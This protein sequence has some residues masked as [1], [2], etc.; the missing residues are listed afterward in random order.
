MLDKNEN[1]VGYLLGRWL[2]VAERAQQAAVDPNNSLAARNMSALGTSPLA[3]FNR[4]SVGT[5]AHLDK[6]R[7]GSGRGMAI[8]LVKLLG[9][10]FAAIGSPPRVMSLESKALLTIGYYTQKQD[11]Y[12]KNERQ[13]E[14]DDN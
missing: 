13:V 9:E 7:K 3:T 11:F 10:I 1:N 5:H 2:A 6:L 14:D 12:K 4:L 8:M